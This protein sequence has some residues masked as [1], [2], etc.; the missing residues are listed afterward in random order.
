MKKTYLFLFIIFCLTSCDYESHNAT[1]IDE[2]QIVRL[3]II[4]PLSGPNALAGQMLSEH[5]NFV[6][7]S[8]NES[9]QNI[10][11]RNK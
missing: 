4:E 3:A 1:K 6:V 11:K 9:K 10:I 2:H 5:L 7:S 8:I